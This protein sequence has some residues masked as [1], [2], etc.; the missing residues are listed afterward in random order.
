VNFGDSSGSN[1]VIE[2]YGETPDGR[3]EV[4]KYFTSPEG[5]AM[6]RNLP[7]SPRERKRS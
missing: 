3:N 4:K 5:T 1:W 2:R 7:E 6:L